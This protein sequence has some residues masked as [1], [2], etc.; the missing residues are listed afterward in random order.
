[1]RFNR[2]MQGRGFGASLIL[3]LAACTDAAPPTGSAPSTLTRLDAATAHAAG[4]SRHLVYFDGGAPSDFAARVS[5]LGGQVAVSYESVGIAVVEGLSESAATELAKDGGINAV[6]ADNSFQFLAPGAGATVD[7]TS[8]A[9]ASPTQ[10][11]TAAFFPFQWNMRVIGADAAWAAGQRGS[12]AVRVAILDTGI[13][14]LHP[15]L[16]GRVD[17]E[18]SASFVPA[19]DPFVPVLFPGRAAFTDLHFHGTHV[20]A[21]VSSNA[22][23]AAGVGSQTTLMA[24]KVI[25][26]S[27]SGT[28]SAILGGIVFATEHGANII[29]ISLGVADLLSRKEREVKAFQRMVDRAFGYAHSKGVMI[30]AAAGN[31]SQ[32]LDAKQTFKAYC[33]S[34][35]VTCVSATGPTSQVSNAGPWT[36]IDAPA[37]YTN[38]GVKHVDLAAPGGNGASVVWAACST[39]SVVIPV[40]QTALIGLGLG[41]TSQAAPHVSGAAALVLAQRGLLQPGVVE[42]IL[43]NSADDIGATG[44]DAFSGRGRLNVGKALGL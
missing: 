24:V 33:G 36:N 34:T 8:A 38:F 41:G 16:A 12:S 13:D 35:H 31:E 5:G 18:N 32:D 17:L 15:D 19:E 11:A 9:I 1:M 43:L 7:A 10:P 27:G 14:Y 42:A 22:F 37:S 44:K 4:T 21:T 25:G 3:F 20:A 2:V 39:T 23:L 26:V 28:A 6:D 30:V 40:C 29:N